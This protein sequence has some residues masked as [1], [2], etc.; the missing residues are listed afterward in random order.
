LHQYPFYPGT[1][2]VDETG[3]GAGAG[4]TLNIPLPA[5]T[6]GDAYR[7][8]FDDAIVPAAEFFSPT[9]VL[10]SC[11]FDA[12]RSDPL[13][14]L[15]LSAGDFGDL[16]ARA[17]RLAPPGRRIFFLEG[18]YDLDAL[19]RSTAATIA[20]LLGETILPEPRTSGTAGEPT[21]TSRQLASIVERAHVL[22]ERLV[23][24]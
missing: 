9:W 17:V 15:G 23:R 20:A 6:A 3:T 4:T 19:Q 7:L 2:A 8:A 21:A 10:V 14:D 1:G 12:H 5:G 22:H 24:P 16:A 11:G 13:T 18:G